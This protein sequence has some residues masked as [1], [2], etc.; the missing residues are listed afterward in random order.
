MS[1]GSLVKRNEQSDEW[2]DRY[3]GKVH[4]SEN[5][6]N[7]KDVDE[8]TDDDSRKI[9]EAANTL[10]IQST[11]ELLKLTKRAARYSLPEPHRLE[12]EML[13]EGYNPDKE[14]PDNDPGA[15]FSGG[16]WAKVV[17]ARTLLRKNVDLLICRRV[18]RCSR[19][20][21]G[22]SDLQQAS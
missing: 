3:Y 7:D 19:P 14:E 16:E 4:E 15:K 20:S 5:E 11:P 8:S 21:L 6:E 13:K 2:E 17:M 18:L 10:L 9:L 1:V 12:G 22:I